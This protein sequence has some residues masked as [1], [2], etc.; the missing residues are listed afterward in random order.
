MHGRCFTPSIRV[1]PSLLLLRALTATPIA[2]RHTVLPCRRATIS[3]HKQRAVSVQICEQSPTGADRYTPASR[4]SA[5]APGAITRAVCV[6]GS[7]GSHSL[8]CPKQRRRGTESWSRQP[9]R[10]P[11]TAM[12][13]RHWDW[14]MP[15]ETRP[16]RGDA[17]GRI[18]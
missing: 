17:L 2:H 11:R 14:D 7:P 5:Y 15:R 3:P 8:R 1:R 12:N 18:A 4:A 9:G 6:T 13:E 16:D 10:R